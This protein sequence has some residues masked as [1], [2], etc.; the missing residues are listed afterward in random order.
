MGMIGK[1]K[2]EAD[3]SGKAEARSTKS[4][5]V[6][7]AS[8]SSSKPAPKA[9]ATKR[10]TLTAE[11]FKQAAA[12]LQLSLTHTPTSASVPEVNGGESG[13]GANKSTDSEAIAELSAT[14]TVFSAGSY[15]WRGQQR[16][17]IELKNP[18]T[19]EKETVNVTINV[20]ATVLGSKPS[21][22]DKAKK[23]AEEEA[24]K[25]DESEEVEEE[26]EDE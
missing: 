26:D 15:G 14:P 2:A 19:G 16:V 20:N 17:N 5:K 21:A 7:K 6:E 23:K 18:E 9:K 1:R 4:A 25:N 12:S 8:K 13:T 24:A 11:A 3:A 10:P 22:K